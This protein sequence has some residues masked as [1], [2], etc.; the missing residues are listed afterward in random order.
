MSVCGIFQK[1]MDFEDI[2]DY[3]K[4]YEKWFDKKLKLWNGIPSVGTFRNISK[5]DKFIV[6]AYLADIGISI[7][8]VKSDG[9]SNEITAIPELL[10]ILT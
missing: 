9:K 2:Y 3:D 6:S 7:G 10:E 5:M 8:Q 1:R 4:A